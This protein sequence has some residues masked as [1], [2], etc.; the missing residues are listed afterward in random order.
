MKMI[1][2]GVDDTAKVWCSAMFWIDIAQGCRNVEIMAD[3]AYKILT[4][5]VTGQFLVDED[6]L[7]S[8]GVYSSI[9]PL[10]FLS[11]II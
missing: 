8:A 10:L 11:Y 7:R 4:S 9:L 2:G 5:K 1:G 3:A 6:V